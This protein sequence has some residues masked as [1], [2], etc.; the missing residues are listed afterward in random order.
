MFDKIYG[1]TQRQDGLTKIG[2]NKYEA[3]YGFGKDT[4]GNYNWREMFTK[5][6]SV[7]TIRESIYQVINDAVSEKI[8]SGMT[9]N[10][11][12]VWLSAENQR[13]YQIAAFRLKAGDETILPVKVKMGTDASPVITEFA[14]TADYLKFFNGI[15]DHISD[16]VNAGWIEKTS[17]DWAV[18]ETEE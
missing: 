1:A 6:P 8:L 17:V 2:R 4:M 16:T 15:S 7:D 10:G 18:Y 3:I 14:T 9:Y 12:Q 11:N 5:K 13:N